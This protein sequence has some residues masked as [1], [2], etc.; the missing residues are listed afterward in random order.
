MRRE[1]AAYWLG[2]SPVARS[3]SSGGNTREARVTIGIVTT[4]AMHI[5]L[6]NHNADQETEVFMP[7]DG[8][9]A[10]WH[11]DLYFAKH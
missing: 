5:R 4:G 10:M 3:G 1:G 8:D 11:E 9:Y 6:R 2:G 7:R